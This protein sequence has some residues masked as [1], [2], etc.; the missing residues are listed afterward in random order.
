MVVK[1]INIHETKQ[2]KKTVSV[3][4]N[5]FYLLLSQKRTANNVAKISKKM[6][7]LFYYLP[8]MRKNKPL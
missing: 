3:E 8:K 6:H 1:R 4:K 2:K 5:K 7:K